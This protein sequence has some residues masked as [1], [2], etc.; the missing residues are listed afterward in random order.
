MER[1][2]FCHVLWEE[3]DLTLVKF[4]YWAESQVQEVSESIRDLVMSDFK[5]FSKASD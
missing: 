4:M 5:K 1:Q 2:H 3:N